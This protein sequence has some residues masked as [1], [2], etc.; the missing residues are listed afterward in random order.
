M[1][2]I[3]ESAKEFKDKYFLTFTWRIKKHAEIIE[4]YINPDEVPLYTF[5][6]QKN[7][8]PFDFF[9]TAVVTLTNKRLL[10][11]RKRIVF[12][13]LV[14]SVTPEMYNDLNLYSGIIWGKI[15]IDTIKEEITFSKIDKTALDD[16]ET[17]IT[18]YMMKEKKEINQID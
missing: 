11:G 6:A 4:K 17:S 8:N 15:T 2:S 9:D 16:I 14:D 7:S 18:S 13:H 3:Y 12:G 10:I 1:K 5:V